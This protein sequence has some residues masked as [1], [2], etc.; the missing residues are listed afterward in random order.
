MSSTSRASR[1]D[2]EFVPSNLEFRDGDEILKKISC[3]RA[4]YLV[5]K[6]HE[7]FRDRDISPCSDSH[8]VEYGQNRTKQCVCMNYYA[9]IF[10]RLY[11]F[12]QNLYDALPSNLT[13]ANSMKHT[14]V[15]W[16][17]FSYFR[18]QP[19]FDDAIELVVCHQGHHQ[20]LFEQFNHQWLGEGRLQK[21]LPPPIALP[22]C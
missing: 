12:L 19:S 7:I 4:R 10:A 16:A 9:N 18:Q 22:S 3:G 2:R 21:S 6:S 14:T 20:T 13:A 5:A 8:R 15:L 11:K 1:R 17:P